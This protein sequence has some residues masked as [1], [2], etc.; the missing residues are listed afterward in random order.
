MGFL[1]GH[2][3]QLEAFPA[4]FDDRRLKPGKSVGQEVKPVQAASRSFPVIK[5]CSKPWLVHDYSGLY[6]IYTIYSGAVYI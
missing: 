5:Q 4:M 3:P 6:T 2:L 1:I